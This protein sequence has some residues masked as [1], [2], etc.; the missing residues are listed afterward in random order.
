MNMTLLLKKNALTSLY[1]HQYIILSFNDAR[2][3]RMKA[4]LFRFY[5]GLDAQLRFEYQKY[6]VDSHE[7]NSK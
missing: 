6:S 7:I 5:S 4:D 2:V 1:I 3:K